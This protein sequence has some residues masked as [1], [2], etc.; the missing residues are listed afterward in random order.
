MTPQHPRILLAVSGSAASRRAAV[1][2]ADLAS[3]VKCAVCLSGLGRRCLDPAEQQRDGRICALL[4]IGL[5]VPDLFARGGG[6]AHDQ[7]GC[8]PDVQVGS[9]LSA[10]DPLLERRLQE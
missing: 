5:P 4:Y 6:G 1:I 3:T 7:A 9:E 10:A 2:A 8:E